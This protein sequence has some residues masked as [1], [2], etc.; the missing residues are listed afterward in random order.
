MLPLTIF[1]Y[2]IMFSIVSICGQW[3][4]RIPHKKVESMLTACF[5]IKHFVAKV[6]NIVFI[7]VFI[8]SFTFYMPSY[9]I[10]NYFGI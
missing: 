4:S 1:Y 5:K 7:S 8:L 10:F 6:Y 2:K 3:L 9:N